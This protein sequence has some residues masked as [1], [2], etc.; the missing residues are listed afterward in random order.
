MTDRTQ[1]EF[2]FPRCHR[3]GVE[4]SFSGGS[5]TSDGG[6]LLVRQADRRT[7]LLSQAA[8]ALGDAR[9]QAS[10]THSL[11]SVLRQRVYGLCLGYEDLNDHAQLREDIALQTAV[12]R[13]RPLASPPTLCRLENRADRAAAWALHRVLVEQF[14]ASFRRAPKELV[15]DFDATDDAVHGEQ[16][17]RFFHGYY[18]HYC[19]LPLYVFCGEHLLVAYLRPSKIDAAKHAW[20]ILSL[21]VKRL[22]QAWPK[23]RIIFRGDS[24]FCRHAMLSWCE[25]HDV[26]YLVGVAR[27]ERLRVLSAGLLERAEHGYAETRTKQRIF[28]E[29]RYAADSWRRTRRVIV[30]AEHADKGANPRYV[31]TNLSGDPQELYDTLYCARGDIENRIKEQQLDLFADRTSCHAWWANQFRLLLASL[32]YTLLHTI[33]RVALGSTELA[34]AQCSTI[35]LRLLKIGAVVLRN[36]RRVRF[37]L[38]SSYPYQTVFARVAAR[39]GVT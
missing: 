17:G 26:G 38:S 36:T 28:G 22:R 25:R 29:V 33:R 32:A 1:L 19:F 15:L 37:L 30:K 9:R 34:R 16:E 6:V 11:L 13:D 20:A 39:L 31:V 4:A 7:G 8:R 24:G 3:R 12:D 2:R 14:I 21:L 5:V 23:V 27:N 18:D 35:R 10:C